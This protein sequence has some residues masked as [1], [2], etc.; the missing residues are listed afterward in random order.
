MLTTQA[1][2]LAAVATVVRVW[3]SL[4]QDYTGMAQSWQ[5]S[6]QVFIDKL[7]VELLV[8]M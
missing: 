4:E 2:Y 5:L 3:L 1:C 8:S 7:S 6:D